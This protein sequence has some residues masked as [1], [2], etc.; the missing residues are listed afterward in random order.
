MIKDD[1]EVFIDTR[2]QEELFRSDLVGI[3]F[4]QQPEEFLK[5][6]DSTGNAVQ[7]SLVRQKRRQYGLPALR[8]PLPGVQKALHA[9]SDSLSQLRETGTGDWM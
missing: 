2:K 3:H 4:F 7:T 6:K 9:S 8:T 5:Q 1:H